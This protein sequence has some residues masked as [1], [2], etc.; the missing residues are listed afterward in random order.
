MIDFVSFLA[1]G[2]TVLVFGLLIVWAADNFKGP[3][4]G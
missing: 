2:I 3:P 1:G 4:K